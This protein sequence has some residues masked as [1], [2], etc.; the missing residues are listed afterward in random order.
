[1][2][3]AD[4]RRPPPDR[5]RQRSLRRSDRGLGAHRGEDTHAQS[6]RRGV[7][8][9]REGGAGS[10]GGAREHRE[11]AH[12]LLSGARV[13]RAGRTLMFL[14]PLRDPSRAFRGDFVAAT[15]GLPLAGLTWRARV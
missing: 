8:P 15:F 14:T 9:D 2:P 11:P 13:R 10:L 6:R 4:P 12:A 3:A 7:L 5:G 1:P